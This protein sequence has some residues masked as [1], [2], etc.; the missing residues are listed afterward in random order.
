MLHFCIPVQQPTSGKLLQG[1]LGN[2]STDTYK[3]CQHKCYLALTA[4]HLH[5]ILHSEPSLML[6]TLNWHGQGFKLKSTHAASMQDEIYGYSWSPCCSKNQF[7]LPSG[8]R[9]AFWEAGTQCIH[10]SGE[11]VFLQDPWTNLILDAVGLRVVNSLYWIISHIDWFRY[12]LGTVPFITQVNILL[13]KIK[14][15]AH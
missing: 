8:Q 3:G 1:I 10:N 7:Y 14:N 4:R 11:I 12:I 9:G 5:L 6:Y 13:Y 2:V 15:C